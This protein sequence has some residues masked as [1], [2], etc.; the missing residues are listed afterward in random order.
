MI[1]ALL[2][3]PL[4]LAPGLA[5]AQGDVQLDRTPAVSSPLPP[6]EPPGPDRAAREAPP[7]D[8]QVL[9][10]PPVPGATQPGRSEGFATGRDPIPPRPGAK[11]D[12][13][14]TEAGQIREGGGA[15]R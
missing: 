7:A 14:T 6:S 5:L 11:P 12:A 8:H 1:R 10:A 3:A 9:G 4:F 2:L 13:P 15:R